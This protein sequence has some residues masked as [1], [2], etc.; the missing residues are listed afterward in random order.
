MSFRKTSG[1]IPPPPQEL[2]RGAREES[3]SKIPTNSI[4]TSNT[5]TSSNNKRIEIENSR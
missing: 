5:S 3:T 2:S 1:I 4:S